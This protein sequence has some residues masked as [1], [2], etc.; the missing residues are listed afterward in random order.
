MIKNLSIR[1]AEVKDINFIT[2]TIVEAEKSGTDRSFICSMYD[3]TEIDYKEILTSLLNEDIMPGFDYDLNSFLIAE[4]EGHSVGAL[5]GWIEEK[6]GIKSGMAQ[7]NCLLQTIPQ[8]KLVNSKKRLEKAKEFRLERKSGTIQLEYGFV[9]PEYRRQ[10]I[11]TNLILENVA[12]HSVENPNVLVHSI[13][14]KGNYKSL[15]AYNKLNFNIIEEKESNDITIKEVF[16]YN[17]K[18]LMESTSANI[19]KQYS[20][21][22][23]TENK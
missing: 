17:S 13:L 12:R 8:E 15:G 11:F 10:G 18:V 2:T 21:L 1:I 3:I 23:N 5:A 4:I 9:L 16:P 6:D 20:T 14:Y 7:A 19:L 22:V